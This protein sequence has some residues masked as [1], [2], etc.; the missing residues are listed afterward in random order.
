ME[1]KKIKLNKLS[2][3]ALAQIS[4]KGLR[5][6]SVVSALVHMPIKE[7]PVLMIKKLRTSSMAMQVRSATL[8]TSV[9]SKSCV[10]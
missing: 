3:D 2:D 8:I 10:K 7:G 9:T 5:V 1:L 6:V 4:Y